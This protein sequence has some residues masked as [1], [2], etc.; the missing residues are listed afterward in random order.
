V[1]G[2]LLL[3][4]A[5]AEIILRL[6]GY[7]GM[8][9]RTNTVIDRE[10]GTRAV[11][12]WVDHAVFDPSRVD[13]V[14]INGQRVPFE[15]RE[16]RT[17]IVFIGDSGT[18]GHGVEPKEAYP[19]VFSSIELANG[20][21]ELEVIN[22]GIRGMTNVG[23]FNLLASRI[24]MLQPDI[25]ILG[26]FM[27]ND[28]NWNLNDR[29]LLGEKPSRRAA[30]WD[31]LRYR[32]AS[33]H[34]AHLQLLAINT[35]YGLINRLKADQPVSKLSA[36]NLIDEDG[37][38]MVDY[39]GGEVATYR[40]H[41]SRL[42]EYAFEVLRDVMWRFKSLADIHGFQFGVLI[43][44]TSSQIEG[45]LRMLTAPTVLNELRDRGIVIDKSDLDVGRPLKVVRD[46]CT[47]LEIVCID[48]VEKL[49][50]I[51]TTRAI[52]PG[53][54]HFTADGHRVLAVSLVAHFSDK[55]RQFFS[56]WSC[57]SG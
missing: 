33:A 51:G 5:A 28:I 50:R 56:C 20:V 52:L 17:R 21:R 44:P 1:F 41:P 15:K 16:G 26:L 10:L 13:H 7:E 40:K 22:A 9:E 36:V 43:I 47:E 38:N 55:N 32:S 37:I 45:D 3:G 14:V 2:G 19:I 39:I 31:W 27:A 24:V 35:K 4:F 42:T 18:E 11:D 34:F 12:A 53:D 48:P 6:V 23:E 25:V 57:P 49:R 29:H 46:L 54:D 30:F 8:E